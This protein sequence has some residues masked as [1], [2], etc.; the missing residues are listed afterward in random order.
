MER[1]G[2]I[3][4]VYT[5]EAETADQYI[6]KTAHA[7]GKKYKVTVATSD[8]TEQVIIRGQG[9]LLLSARELQQE[10]ARISTQIR[11]EHLEQEER[12]GH[13]LGEYL[14]DWKSFTS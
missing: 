3:S 13:Y 11:K 9:C 12:S 2:D 6:E 4:I 10:I 7:I 14:P 1:F 5:K 8:G